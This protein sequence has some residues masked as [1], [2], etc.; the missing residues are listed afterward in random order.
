ME[1]GSE[2]WKQLL[3]NDITMTEVEESSVVGNDPVSALLDKS[4][5]IMLSPLTRLDTSPSRKLKDILRT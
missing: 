4:T 3:N 1:E 2:P 5:E